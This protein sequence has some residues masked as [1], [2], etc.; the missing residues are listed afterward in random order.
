[1]SGTLHAVTARRV[2]DGTRLHDNA[3]VLIDRTHIVGVIPRRELAA[4]T[5][6]RELPDG[7]WLRRTVQ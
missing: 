7:A 6:S 4:T 5:P 1:M 3:A 2:F